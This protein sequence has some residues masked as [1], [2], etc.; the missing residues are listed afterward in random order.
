M[1][2][3]EC[4]QF[5]KMGIHEKF[6]YILT[7]EGPLLSHVA[8]FVHEII[9]VKRDVSVWHMYS[10]MWYSDVWKSPRGV[11]HNAYINQGP[12]MLI[13]G[14]FWLG[15]FGG[16]AWLWLG[17]ALASANHS[18]AFCWGLLVRSLLAL[19]TW[20]PGSSIASVFAARR[21]NLGQWLRSFQRKLR[22][23]WLRF[24]RRVAV[25]LVFAGPCIVRVN[26]ITM[27]CSL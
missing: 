2:R 8:K 7:Y 6:I 23:H 9:S 16:G 3:Q 24:L 25:T 19:V 11:Y 17:D 14:V 21:R 13:L 27:Y 22:S 26:C 5:D 1:F 15:A 12:T 18:R 4:E 10:K 20:A